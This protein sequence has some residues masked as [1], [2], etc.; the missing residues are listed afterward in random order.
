MKFL[1][2]DDE[3]HSRIFLQEIMLQY[4]DEWKLLGVCSSISESIEAI[5]RLKPDLVLMDIEIGEGS[6]FD[7][8]NA[9]EK[10]DFNI[11][12]ISAFEQ[13]ALK[14]IKYA[15]LDYIL[16]PVNVD[17]LGQALKKISLNTDT[18]RR[19]QV[20]KENLVQTQ[21][22]SNIM[23]PTN[24]GYMMVNL[25]EI[26]YLEADGQ[27]VYIHLTDQRKILASKSLGHY[28]ELLGEQSFFRIHKS[29]IVNISKVA[30]VI[31]NPSPKVELV[32][33]FYLDLAFRRKESFIEKLRGINQT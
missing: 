22:P 12:F 26:C 29:Y 7:V 16:K 3:P 30:R 6:A 28:E 2:I 5:K 25:N 21:M 33:G 23:I 17:E 11:I 10:P 14:A 1:I 31:T 20:L 8:I 32:N 9:F 24:K 15:A 4:F 19:M 27:Y 18:S 13:Y